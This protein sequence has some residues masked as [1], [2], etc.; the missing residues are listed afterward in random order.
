MS[1]SKTINGLL[2]TVAVAVLLFWGIGA[3]ANGD[4]LWFSRTFSDDVVAVSIYMKGKVV[5]LTPDD[6]GFDEIAQTFA[7]A[8]GNWKAYESQVTLSETSLKQYYEQGMLLEVNYRTPV[9]LHTRHSFSAA[10]TYLMPLDGTHSKYSRVFGYQNTV[11]WAIGCVNLAPEYV[12]QLRAS[13]QQVISY[14]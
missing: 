13:V 14:Q 6:P 2:S 7:N 10:R 4:P 5:T 8:M 11:P 1:K 12:D 3:L 9:Q